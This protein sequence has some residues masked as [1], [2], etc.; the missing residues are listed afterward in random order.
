MQETVNVDMLFAEM[1]NDLHSLEV[2]T[3]RSLLELDSDATAA[4]S[5]WLD[6]WTMLDE[7]A[8]EAAPPDR[9]PA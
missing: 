8:H 3:A 6:D 1:E 7:L 9:S 5:R 4:L 2:L